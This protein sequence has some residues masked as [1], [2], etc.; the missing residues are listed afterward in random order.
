M[1]DTVFA[2]KL[3]DMFQVIGHVLKVNFSNFSDG[4]RNAPTELPTP[5]LNV[6]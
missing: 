4:S 5:P 3:R 6:S 2:G 1:I